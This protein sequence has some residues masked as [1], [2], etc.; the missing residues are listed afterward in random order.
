MFGQG[1]GS[2]SKEEDALAL[3]IRTRV[4]SW[5][6]NCFFDP[7]AGIDWKNRMDKGQ[8]DGLI[9]EI[10]SVLLG[11]NGVVKV[12]SVNAVLDPETRNFRIQYN[13]DTIYTQSFQAIINS[14]SGV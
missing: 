8:K 4:L 14:L 3:S 9:N 11:T 1:L 10:N 5:F 7:E 13:V 6:G 12:N 2:Y